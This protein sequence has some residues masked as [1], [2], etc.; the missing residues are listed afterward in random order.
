MYRIGKQH[1]ET[2][3]DRCHFY[4]GLLVFHS[5]GYTSDSLGFPLRP[6]QIEIVWATWDVGI[7]GIVGMGG[8]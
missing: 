1:A 8:L 5:V 3:L 6:F 4:F 2:I 7:V